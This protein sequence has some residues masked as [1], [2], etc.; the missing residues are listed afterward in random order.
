MI[1]LLTGRFSP[2]TFSELLERFRS[3]ERF[4]SPLLQHRLLKWQP[5]S[6]HSSPR[7]SII[8]GLANSNGK[9]SAVGPSS[10]PTSRRSSAA[11][12]HHS[13]SRPTTPLN[14]TVNSATSSL[15]FAAVATAVV[16][17]M[18]PSARVASKPSSLVAA[19]SSSSSSAPSG[20]Y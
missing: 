8:S 1:V 17:D 3:L 14:N 5:D 11:S 16:V 15:Q 13:D 7:P 2:V 9:S 18:H 12:S 19:S 10:L 20:N 6:P 4:P